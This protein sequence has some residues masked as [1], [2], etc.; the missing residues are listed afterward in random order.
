M[1]VIRCGTLY[2]YGGEGAVYNH[3]PQPLIS[4]HQRSVC[5]LYL[6]EEKAIGELAVASLY[7]GVLR[8]PPSP[9]ALDLDRACVNL[10][11]ASLHIQPHLPPGHTSLS[12]SHT[13]AACWSVQAA[14]RKKRETTDRNL[15]HLLCLGTM[16]DWWFITQLRVLVLLFLIS[17]WSIGMLCFG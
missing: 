15:S 3:Q 12:H 2:C 11:A 7:T 8:P 4:A 17:S 16:A 9:R 10:A 14:P 1:Y 5:S 6:E 13:T